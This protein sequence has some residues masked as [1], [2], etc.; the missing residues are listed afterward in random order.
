[1]LTIWGRKSSSN[2]QAVLWCVAELNLPFQRIDAGLTYGVTDTAEYLSMNPNGRIPTIRDDN[3]PPVWE[4]GAI[5]RY[6]ANKYADGAFWPAEPEA[7]AVVDQWSEWSKVNITALFTHPIFWKVV[8]TPAHLRD[9][10]AI[11]NAIKNFEAMLQI[12]D[13]QLQSNN[14]IAGSKFTLADIQFGHILYRYFDIPVQRNPPEAVTAYY[15]N[16]SSRPAYQKH[17]AVS[18]EELKA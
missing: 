13:R 4:S 15:Q 5:L 7:R 6:L 8:R 17:V 18:Y 9:P 3:N 1:M 12:A 2:V 10:V 14:Y 16:V 11:D